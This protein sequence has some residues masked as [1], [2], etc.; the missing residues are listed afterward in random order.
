MPQRLR[1]VLHR[2][3]HH[4]RFTWHAAWQTGWRALRAAATRHAL[5]GV[6]QT[7]TTGFLWGIAAV[8]R[9]VPQRP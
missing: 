8:G 9:D 2:A 4:Q 5:R 7:R 3:V 6:W 1:C